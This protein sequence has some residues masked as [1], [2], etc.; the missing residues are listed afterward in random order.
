LGE[1]FSNMLLLLPI[2]SQHSLCLVIIDTIHNLQDTNDNNIKPILA[3]VKTSGMFLLPRKKQAKSSPTK[4]FTAWTVNRVSLRMLE[5][6]P[7][8]QNAA[9]CVLEKLSMAGKNVSKV[10]VA[11]KAAIGNP[12]QGMSQDVCQLLLHGKKLSS[13]NST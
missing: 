6:S 1:Y 7:A 9:L 12:S 5:G 13:K 2:P 10:I 4:Y 11:L 3:N 8:T